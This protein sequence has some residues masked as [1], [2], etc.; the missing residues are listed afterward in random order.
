[1]EK[2]LRVHA[3]EPSWSANADLPSEGSDMRMPARLGP[4]PAGGG[5][6]LVRMPSR[7]HT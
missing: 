3:K 5:V 6:V 4:S 1:M 2:P 7:D